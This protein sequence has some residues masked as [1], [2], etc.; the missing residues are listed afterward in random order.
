[1]ATN[2]ITISG[3]TYPVRDQLKALGGRWNPDQKAWTVPADQAERARELVSGSRPS[4]PGMATEKQRGAIGKLLRRIEHIRQF[5]SF[6]G[7][8]SMLATEIRDQIRAWGGI[9]S[10]T[11]S[12]ASQVIGQLIAAA[13]DEM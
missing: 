6:G 11:S 9:T 8:G 13:D 12:Q 7:N 2:Y 4:V 10:L 3:N 1:M 5:D